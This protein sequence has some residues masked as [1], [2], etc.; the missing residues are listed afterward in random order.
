MHK[1]NSIAFKNFKFFHNEET[2]VKLDEKNLLLYGENG[3]GKSSIYWGLYTLFQSVYKEKENVDVYFDAKGMKSLTNSHMK[4]GEDS[5]VKL[6]LTNNGDDERESIICFD[7]VNTKDEERLVKQFA[8]YSSF[9][10]FKSLFN[11]HN[12]LHSK[13]IDLF[14]LFE[15]DILNSTDFGIEAESLEGN[16]YSNSFDVWKEIKEKRLPFLDEAD[17]GEDEREDE[18]SFDKLIHDFN[19]AFEAY[20]DK[21]NTIV[22]SILETNFNYSFK[23]KFRYNEITRNALV[24]NYSQAFPP[25]IGVRI[26]DNDFPIHRPQSFLNEA[27]LTAIALAIKF[28]IVLEKYIPKEGE[29]EFTDLPKLLVLDDIMISM[30]MGNREI[31]S[32]ILLERFKDYQM[33][34]F[35]HD[36]NLFDYFKYKLAGKG[37]T[38]EWNY[39]EM[40]S[41]KMSSDIEFPQIIDSDLSLFDTADKYWKSFRYTECAFFIR[42]AFEKEIGERLPNE[43]KFKA[44]GEF[45]TLQSMWDK[46]VDRYQSIGTP[47][48]ENLVSSFRQSKLLVLNPQAH[49]QELSLPVYQNELETALDTLKQVNQLPVPEIILLLSKGTKLLFKHPDKDYTFEFE[50]SSN[51]YINSVVNI[52]PIHYPE[53]KVIKFSYEGKELFSPGQNKTIT[54]EELDNL[55]QTKLPRLIENCMKDTV[56]N[57]TEKMFL[58]NTSIMNSLFRLKDVYV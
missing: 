40:Y 34:F 20:L 18:E 52:T 54:K 24:N 8:Q 12:F 27:K 13:E 19:I 3:S 57:I 11:H 39:K 48:P 29:E 4:E 1:I 46:L 50:L 51:Y 35:T 47:I 6:S 30:D 15:Y 43:L 28:A 16:D 56:L 32:N 41:G 9:I 22:E 14:P 26:T 10:N 58:D 44:N 17:K 23:I 55:V 25:K 31:V 37:L 7:T 38:D 5:F 45:L 42:K 36:K 53:C 49:Y 21:I 33:I 2:I